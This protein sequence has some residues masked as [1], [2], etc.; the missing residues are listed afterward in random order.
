MAEP[1]SVGVCWSDGSWVAVAFTSDGFDHAEV[2]DGVGECWSRYEDHA[3]RILV[4]IPIGLVES[5]DP[6][7]RCD[8]LARSILGDRS[9]AVRTPPV[10]EATRKRRY[11]T[12]NRV[13]RRK[14]DQDL[15]EQAFAR[16]DGIARVDEL[17]QELPE[18]AAVV[19]ESHPEVCFRAFAGEPLEHSKRTAAGYA[20]RMRTLAHYDRDAAPTVQKAAEGTSG[21][22]VAVDDVLDAVALAY[23]AA[24]GGRDLRTLPPDPP[25]DPTGLPMEIAYRA[26]SPLVE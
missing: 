7:R 3:Q 17:L 19:R 20:E 25:R 4:D 1:L 6:T 14:S 15:S 16:S 13:H 12:A 26:A 18:A 24:P 5:G 23:T 2:Y 21:A 10:R 22:T 11:S 8:T 9:A